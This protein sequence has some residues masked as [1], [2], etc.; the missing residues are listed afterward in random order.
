[1]LVTVPDLNL[2]VFVAANTDTGQRLAGRLAGQVVA[3]FY[4]PP[5]DLPR[6]GSPALVADRNVYAGTYLTTRRPYSGLEKFVFLLIGQTRISVT[7]DGHL[8][9]GGRTWTPDGPAGRFRQIDGPLTTAFAIEDGRAQRWFPPSGTTA[10]DRVGPLYQIRTLAVVAALAV[11]ASIATLVGVFTRDRREF[12]QTPMQNRAG[13]VQTTI[14]V[15][16]LM[17][18]ALAGSWAAGAG[19]AGRVMYHWPGPAL[20]IASA[21]ALTAALLTL[22]TILMAPSV[23]RGGRRVDSWTG[24]R[25][26]R[27]TMTTMI[28]AAFSV[29]LGLW[30]ALAPWSG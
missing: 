5:G 19:D 30:G 8:L 20:I 21:C 13:L 15:L 2:G 11:L 16:W 27:F 25:K 29:M 9:A 4:A 3:Q 10:F 23:W 26:L 17:A 14:S 12:R 6:P 28:F 7:D 22:L 18:I 1:M 24:W